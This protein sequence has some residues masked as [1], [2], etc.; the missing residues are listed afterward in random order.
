MNNTNSD[1]YEML[2]SLSLPVAAQRFAELTQSPEM[3]N[4]TPLQLLREVL[5]PQYTEV[6]N[7]RFQTNLRLSSLINKGAQ[8]EN[9]KTGNGRVYNDATVQQILEFHFAENRQNVGI[10]GVTGAG[11]SYFLSA[12]CVEACRRNYRSKFVDYSDLLD[13]LIILNRQEDLNRYR[14]RIKYYAKIQLLF[15][16]DFAISRYSEEETDLI[17]Q[18]FVHELVHAYRLCQL[19]IKTFKDYI[20]YN[21]LLCNVI[22]EEIVASSFEKSIFSVLSWNEIMGGQFKKIYKEDIDRCITAIK[23]SK[24]IEELNKLFLEERKRDIIYSFCKMYALDKKVDQLLP[25]SDK[26]GLMNIVYDSGTFIRNQNIK[27]CDYD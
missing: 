7:N 2:D 19:K 16:D 17:Y 25:L 22:Y 4:Y 26:N 20:V 23:K 18:V 11:K 13:E 9:L 3:G 6:L 10:Y 5:E 15:I 24:D 8:V 12:C 1:I 21:N 27:G 14:K